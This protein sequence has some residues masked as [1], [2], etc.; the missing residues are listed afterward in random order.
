MSGLQLALRQV[1]YENR[2]F[3]RN[4]A[5]AF[6]T[7]IFPLMF[8]VIFNLVF[9]DE[10]MDTPNGPLDLS[11]FYVPAIAALSVISACFTNIAIT[12]SFQRDEGIL[13]RKRGT[14]LP[15][16]AYLFGR[17]VHSTLLALG[18]VVLVTV[19]GRLFY[20][21]DIPSNTLPAAI[22]TVLL[23]AACFSSLGLAVT[24]MIRDAEAAPPT[25][26]AIVLPLLFISDVFI[27][28]DEGAPTW[29]E[30]L[31]SVFPIIHFSEALQTVFDPFEEGAGFEWDRLGI[32]ALWTVIGIG[33]SI[34][35]FRWEP[36]K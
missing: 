18:L 30:P 22:V 36:R 3:W 10:E 27:P 2:S 16:W 7:V 14:P 15:S 12:T 23:G 24:G 11:N 33:L 25:T 19:V 20:G 28:L 29:L 21:V 31:A 6:F 13:K 5:A 4:S 32:M 9:G 1:K 17:I 34:K 26:N 35:F 8:L